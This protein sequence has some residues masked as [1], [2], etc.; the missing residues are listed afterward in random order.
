MTFV[1]LIRSLATVSAT[2]PTSSA[3]RRPR[4]APS[5]AAVPR[6][7]PSA[8]APLS[9][10]MSRSARSPGAALAPAPITAA[11]RPAPFPPTSAS[12][13][14]A[15]DEALSARP[16]R[17]SSR[18]R[19]FALAAMSAPEVVTSNTQP[20]APRRAES[21]VTVVGSTVV[22]VTI[23]AATSA[24]ALIPST[25]R[26]PVVSSPCTSA[27]RCPRSP[28]VRVVVSSVRSSTRPKAPPPAVATVAPSAT[29]ALGAP[30]MPPTRSPAMVAGPSSM[31]TGSPR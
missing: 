17:R 16:G 14:A 24:L 31:L 15:S 7:A 3:S 2:A 9:P 18:L 27:P 5:T 30:R 20:T 19:R 26:P 29:R 4:R 23:A 10:S 28:L 22:G 12:G 21:G 6:S 13:T 8:L 11:A 1:K 25:L